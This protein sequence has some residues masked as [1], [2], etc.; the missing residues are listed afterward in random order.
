M[1]WIDNLSL[2][3]KLALG[4]AV[5][6]ALLIAVAAAALWGFDRLALGLEA[7]YTNRLPSYSF[8][9]RLDAQLRDM[10]GL[11]H[12]SITLEAVGYGE[13][14]I[15]ATDRALLALAAEVEA[16]LQQRRAEG[17]GDAEEQKT[18][19][20]LTAL[21]PKFRRNIQDTVDIKTNGLATATTFLS[22]AHSQY[23]KLLDLTSALSRRKLE[24]AGEDV[25]ASRHAADSAKLLI[26]VAAGSAVLLAIG[27]GVLIGHGMLKRV[28]SL[29]NSAR[30]LAAGDLTTRVDAVGSDEVGRLM[31]DVQTVQHQL[32]A[33]LQKVR[34]ATDTVRLAATEI[35]AGNLNLGQRT[36]SASESLQITAS[37]MH[38]LNDA[39]NRNA[40][41]A[42]QA[43]QRA[44]DAAGVAREGG[45]AM[46]QVVQTMGEI[47]KSSHR[48]AEITSVIDGIAFQTN[49]LAL[50]AAVEAA[51][52][53]DQGRGFAV[54]AGEVRLLAHRSAA[55]AREITELITASVTRIKDGSQLVEKAGGTIDL[56]VGRAADVAQL[57]SGIRGATVSQ[58]GEIAQMS[59]SLAEL[60]QNTKQN[61]VLVAQSSAAAD[62]MRVQADD[63][64][65][66]VHRFRLA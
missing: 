55:A 44:E 37:A 39:V 59:Q 10:N 57:I 2:K 64:S 36:E 28:R 4:P 27:F 20:A 50:N 52:A 5:C 22:T 61:S 66:A 45:K 35:A 48:I 33:S 38:E 23:V 16:S 62:R 21:Y 13:K 12:R 53:G 46:S 8:A 58:S 3:Y 41:A 42:Q 56:L 63:L 14:E 34:S 15:A 9:A 47:T 19:E 25:R 26:A 17:T 6:L 32:A 24:Q 31:A 1:R 29:S 7:L 65:Q 40:N 49:I 43:S 54:V 60:D 51:R 11:V 18:I 30:A